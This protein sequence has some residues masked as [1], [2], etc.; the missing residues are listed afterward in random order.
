MG[1]IAFT[2]GGAPLYLY[3]TA[4]SVALLAALLITWW[5]TW[6][7]DEP[8]P[9][10]F[11]VFLW[12][13][14]LGLVGARLVHVVTHASLYLSDPLAVLRFWE[15]GFSFYGSALGFLLALFI[16]SSREDFPFLLWLDVIAPA[17]MLLIATYSFTTFIMQQTVGMLEGYLAEFWP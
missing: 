8:F 15:G 14:P 6:L 2:I 4:A 7:Y 3:G 5:S 9:Y 10:A 12:G 17:V 1:T 13:I 16:V 11:D